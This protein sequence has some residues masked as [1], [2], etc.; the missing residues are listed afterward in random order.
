MVEC[1]DAEGLV[2]V[3][4]CGETLAGDSNFSMSDF[5]GVADAW[6]GNKKQKYQG[7]RTN[8]VTKARDCE[9][10]RGKPWAHRERLTT[11]EE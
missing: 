1:L 4:C 6:K 5:M 10:F 8:V 11:D 3:L 9:C 2:A 7:L